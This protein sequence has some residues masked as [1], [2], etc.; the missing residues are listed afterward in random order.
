MTSTDND[1]NDKDRQQSLVGTENDN[2]GSSVT[3]PAMRGLD[4][5]DSS[6]NRVDG[7]MGSNASL[8]NLQLNQN[9]KETDWRMVIGKAVGDVSDKIN[10][11]LIA[12]R[13]GTT[14]TIVLLGA[15]GLSN[16]PLFFRFKTVADIPGKAKQRW[17]DESN[18]RGQEVFR[19][20]SPCRPVVGLYLFT[21]WH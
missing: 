20:S 17:T 9:K 15:Y 10:E 14:A 4:E 6:G 5:S 16:T 1:G 13:Y 18:Q 21:H 7:T 19:Q 12:V 3:I 8:E 2:N 11:N